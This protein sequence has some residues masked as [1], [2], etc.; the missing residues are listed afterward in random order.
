MTLLVNIMP[1]KI[2]LLS[3]DFAYITA[4]RTAVSRSAA[5]KSAQGQDGC[6]I[7]HLAVIDGW[8]WP[9]PSIIT[10]APLIQL[11]VYCSIYTP[12]FT[13]S[14]ALCGHEWFHFNII[15]FYRA[16]VIFSYCSTTNEVNR[17]SSYYLIARG[18][19]YYQN[20]GGVSLQNFM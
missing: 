15:I 12:H 9:P 11:L 6:Q 4:R 8:P 7:I 13:S 1:C 14:D 16:M 17:I 5:C 18:R 19:F 2:K 20:F 10:S 3:I